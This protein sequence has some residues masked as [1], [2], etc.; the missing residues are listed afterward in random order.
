VKKAATALKNLRYDKNGYFFLIDF[1]YFM[2]SHP[3]PKLEGTDTSNLKDP[4]GVYIVKEL[5]KTAR[6]NGDQGGYTS[7]M[8]KT[9]DGTRM[10]PKLSYSK[11][12]KKWNV[13]IGTGIYIDDIDVLVAKEREKVKGEISS[14]IAK[15]AIISVIIVMVLL[16]II[17]YF[18]NR[19]IN[20][21]MG[22]I[23]EGIKNFGNDLTKKI[24][25]TTDDEIGELTKWVNSY[26]DN[27]HDVIKK[28]SDATT[29]INSG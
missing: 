10:Q 25:V 14:L 21:P 18:V 16:A 24:P 7:Y 3:D 12:L 28:V 9:P 17:T 2:I 6:E 11:V 13:V 23:S 26:I 8:W 27:M 4:N 29:D 5:V 22:E 20:K 1:N 19:Y 15:N